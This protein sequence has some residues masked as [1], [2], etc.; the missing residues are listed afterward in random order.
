[1]KRFIPSYLIY[2]ISLLLIQTAIFQSFRFVFLWINFEKIDPDSFKFFKLML[3]LGLRFDIIAS[4]YILLLPFILFTFSYFFEKTKPAV[5]RFVSIYLKVVLVVAFLICS[6]DIPFF[7]FFNSRL[8]TS[9]FLWKD[10]LGDMAKFIFTDTTKYFYLVLMVFASVVSIFLLLKL[11]KRLFKNNDNLAKHSL[12]HKTIVSFFSLCLL[13]IGMWGGISAKPLT[14]KSI[15]YTNHYFINQLS[16]NPLLSFYDSFDSFT[17]DYLETTTAVSKASV[18]LK[19]EGEFDSPIART[20]KAG[21]NPVK[22]NVVLVIMESMS[23]SKVGFMG[24]KNKLTPNLDYLAQ[25]G[26]TFSNVYTNGLHTCNGIYGTLFSFPSLMNEHPMNNMLSSSLNFT[27]FY[28]SLSENNYQTAFMC[29]NKENFDNMGAFVKKNGCDHIYS[30]K[31]FPKERYVGAWGPPDEILFDFSIPWINKLAENKSPF[32]T[33][34]VTISTH[35]PYLLPE[36]TSFKPKSADKIDQTYEYADWSIGRFMDSC[37]MQPWFTNTIFVFIADHGINGVTNFEIPL[38]FHHTPFIIYSPQLLGKP[39]TY[40]TMGMQSDVFPTVMGLLN[41]SYVNNTFGIDLIRETRP[42]AYF[43][44][45]DKLG[46]ISDEYFLCVEKSGNR[47]LYSYRDKSSTDLV[48]AKT[49]LAD[50]MQTY[51]MSMLQTAQ[52]MLINKKTG[53]QQK[54]N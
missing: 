25:N 31:N 50:S 19:G 29:T 1:M 34:L 8:S 53:P 9:A 23:A 6:A 28:Q 21:R 38:S 49:A 54:K 20:V 4:C 48:E 27:G 12:L 45:D 2:L 30:M 39:K 42:F 15:G 32:F 44:D 36:F 13:I 7:A 24:N 52:W 46:C 35:E 26:Y 43:S 22:A 5:Y 14:I 11:Q 51:A 37:K 17:L 18:Y 16:W 47:S 3:Y 41:L 10:N 33:T 40:S